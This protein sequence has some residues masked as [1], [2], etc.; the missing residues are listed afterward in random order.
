[1][2]KCEICEKSVRTGHRISINRSQVSRRANR[3]WKP[4]VKKIKII[5]NGTVKSI[6]ICTR[7]LRSNKVTRAI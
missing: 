6:N 7:C 2:A 4:N 3:T 1:M 5:E